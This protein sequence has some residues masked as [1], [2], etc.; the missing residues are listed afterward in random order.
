[1]NIDDSQNS[2]IFITQGEAPLGARLS[3]A[4][5]TTQLNPQGLVQRFGRCAPEVVERFVAGAEPEKLVTT[6]RRIGTARIVKD[7]T[8][9]VDAAGDF[10]AKATPTQR[11]LMPMM[12]GQFLSASAT[13]LLLADEQKDALDAQRDAT[14]ETKKTAEARVKT[15]KRRAQA[16][17]KVLRTA[18]TT[19]ACGDKA[20]ITRIDSAANKGSAPDELADSLKALIGVARELRARLD[21][22][23]IEHNFTDALFGDV[24]RL[25]AQLD[26]ASTVTVSSEKKAATGPTGVKRSDGVSLWF[27]QRLVDAF[28]AAHDEDP[29]IERLQ[30]HSL[31]SVLRRKSGG[32]KAATAAKPAAPVENAPRQGTPTEVPTKPT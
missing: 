9:I 16:R 28:D 6:G 30:V 18:L 13:A 14:T 22:N 2:P 15:L 23:K 31:R 24:L 25:A 11:A 4:P 12:T 3:V 26:T 17:R 29:S 32:R 5:G 8:R 1:M 20:W 27:L 21:A 10:L 7:G 19:A